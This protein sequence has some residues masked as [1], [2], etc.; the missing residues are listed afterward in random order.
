[1]NKCLI[2]T[3]KVEYLNQI[4]LSSNDYRCIICADGGFEIAQ[5]L[6]LRQD[7]LIGD[8]DSCT[9]PDKRNAIILPAEKD[10]TDTEAALDLAV[11]KNYTY[12]DILGGLGG[13][14][15]HTMGNIGLLAKYCGAI[16]HLT[17]FDGA[18]YVF[19]IN[20]SSVLVKKG[21]YKYISLISYGETA[22]DVCISGVK[23]PLHNFSLTNTTTIGVSNEILSNE[24]EISFSK[25]KL[26]IILSKN[27]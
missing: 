1:M 19:M 23:Y 10:M 11:S 7:I 12:I 26:L 15:D 27:I 20:P 22:Q 17:I 24:A 8:Y 2:V 3:S 4:N 14:F 5:K 25:G 16:N 6:K 13:R 9:L 18:N 21:S